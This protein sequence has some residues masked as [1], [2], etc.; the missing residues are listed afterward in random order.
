MNKKIVSIVIWIIIVAGIIG[1]TLYLL[2]AKETKI[3]RTST[4]VMIHF[5]VGSPKEALYEK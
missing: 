4:F 3:K 5:E 2:E 1:V